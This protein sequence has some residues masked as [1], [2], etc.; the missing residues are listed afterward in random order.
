MSLLILL[1]CPDANT[2][3]RPY[4]AALLLSL[5]TVA[6]ETTNRTSS[7]HSRKID[8]WSAYGQTTLNISLNP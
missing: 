5:A 2:K 1:T 6:P 7:M 4:I 3:L 8:R